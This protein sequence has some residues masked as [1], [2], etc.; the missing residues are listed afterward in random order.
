MGN[1]L[2]AMQFWPSPLEITQKSS[3]ARIY[4]RKAICA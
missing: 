2:V 3:D 4:V 1:D